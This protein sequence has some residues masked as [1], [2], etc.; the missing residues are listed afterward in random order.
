MSPR[1]ASSEDQ[2]PDRAR[3]VADLLERPYAVGAER[4]E[5]RRLRLHARR[6]TGRPA[7]TMPLQK[8]A[9]ADAAAARPS[10]ASPRSSIG[11][12]SSRRVEADERAGCAS[13]RRPLASRSAKP[14]GRVHRARLHAHGT[15]GS[16]V[17][18]GEDL[19]EASSET[20]R[21][22]GGGRRRTPATTT[23]SSACSGA[24]D[25]SRRAAASARPARASSAARR[26][27]RELRTAATRPPATKNA[28]QKPGS[29]AG[30]RTHSR[31]ARS[32]S[33][34]AISPRD[35]LERGE[36]VAEPCG[37]LEAEVAREPAELRRG[38]GAAL[39]ARSSPS[40]SSSARAASCARRLLEIGPEPAGLR[41]RP[42]S[43]SPR[44]SRYDVA[45][46]PRPLAR[47]RAG[48]AR[49]SGGAPRAPPRARSRARATRPA[50]ARRAR[51]RPPG[52]AGR[53]A[54]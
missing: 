34:S 40:K 4:L 47:S 3:V 30:A 11:S 24:N 18:G 32:R 31:A 35:L 48:G 9:T 45:V 41:R 22:S 44:R 13:A 23:S 1:F 53:S 52:A 46:G 43:A 26:A 20:T 51:P 8:R 37:V 54:K 38:A 29:R 12:R 21:S 50:R 14:G 10:T 25:R 49:G 33:S 27:R 15:P 2:Q 16:R 7:S 5:E 36:A 17:I 6:R 39:P 19:V 28:R 42:P